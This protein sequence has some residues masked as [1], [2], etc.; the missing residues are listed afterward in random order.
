MCPPDVE[1]RDQIF[2]VS[3]LRRFIR[4]HEYFDMY[5][6][7]LKPN[8]S[9]FFIQTIES[10]LDVLIEQSNIEAERFEEEDNQPGEVKQYK[11]L[12]PFV[13]VYVDTLVKNVML[14]IDD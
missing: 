7:L 4:F 14:K 12:M 1:N 6:Q 2:D 8:L 10:F 11:K 5:K 3:G 9:R 13:M